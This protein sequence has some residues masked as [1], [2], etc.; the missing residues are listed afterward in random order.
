MPVVTITYLETRSPQEL[1]P[2][3]RPAS[4]LAIQEVFENQWQQSRSYYCAVGAPWAWNDKRFWSDEQWQ[5][6]AKAPELR[7]FIA[8]LQNE[9]VGYFELHQSNTTE[10]EIAYFGL[11]PTFVGR[12]LGGELLTKTLET[13]WQQKPSRVWVHTCDLDHPAALANY[14]AR[15]MA[16]YKVEVH[17]TPALE[18]EKSA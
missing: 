9:P 14:Q 15:G 5:A 12:G 10:I 18:A 13:A 1:R 2:P 16:V 6:Y 3:N 17:E 8:Y 4:T 11:L 7:T